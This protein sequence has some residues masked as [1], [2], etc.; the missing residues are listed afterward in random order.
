M[1]SIKEIAKLAGVSPATVSRV[2]NRPDYKCRDAEARDRIWKAA[3][4]L[5][6]APNE[7]A[8]SL[9]KSAAGGDGAARTA[10]RINVLMTR[11]EA[12]QTDPF[13][14]ELLH[15]I[16]SEIHNHGHILTNVWHMPDFSDDRKCRQLDLPE[17]IDGLYRQT[18]GQNNGLIIIGRCSHD[19]IALL[20]KKFKNL[21]SVN[22]NSTN[23]A[24]D[25][26][27]CDGEKVSSMAVEYLIKLGHTAIGYVGA[28]YG[29]ARFRGFQE[30]L[31]AHKLYMDPAFVIETHQTEQEGYRAMEHI[32]RS[33]YR[34]GAIYCANDITAIGMLDCLKHFRS[35]SYTPAIIAS[36][37][38]ERAQFSDP[39][40]TTIALPKEEMG[41]FA[42]SL[43]LDRIRGGHASVVRM[44]LEGKLLVR[45]SC[46]SVL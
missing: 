46:V 41:R 13:F 19:V 31:L 21:V 36:D 4:E 11:S 10:Y 9:R 2:L 23:Y 8:R 38:I 43:L 39:M 1:A 33:E 3:I 14:T 24:I 28:C 20:Q 5:D 42:I 32:L 22:R 40:L 26:V 27:L 29:E 37:N 34:P 45:D 44:E 30:T 12:K 25:E 6:Y 17:I 35:L 15:I 18:N 16:E 7:A